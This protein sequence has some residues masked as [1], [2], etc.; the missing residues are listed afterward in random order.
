MGKQILDTT[1]GDSDMRVTYEYSVFMQ[2]NGTEAFILHNVRVGYKRPTKI[3]LR[4]EP[5]YVA[6]CFELRKHIGRGWAANPDFYPK[7]EATA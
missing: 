4:A 5:D 7:K 1:I 2:T 6:W 3:N